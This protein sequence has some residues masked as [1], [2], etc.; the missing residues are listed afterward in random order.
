ML[1]FIKTRSIAKISLRLSFQWAKFDCNCS[2]TCAS[3]T[4]RAMTHKRNPPVYLIYIMD[5]HFVE[6]KSKT[7][8]KIA[9]HTTK[10]KP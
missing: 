2:E 4:A 10:S 9:E 5:F 8:A 1:F 7:R 3:E 6:Y